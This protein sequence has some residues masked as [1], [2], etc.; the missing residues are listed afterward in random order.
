MQAV[1][2][3]VQL[4]EKGAGVVRVARVDCH[5]LADLPGGPR[6]R[7]RRDDHL[8]IAQALEVE[9]RAPERGGQQLHRAPRLVRHHRDVDLPAVL[10]GRWHPGRAADDP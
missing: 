8:M 10:G 6:P 9:R 2:Q 3:R 5:D 7:G 1:E 4:G